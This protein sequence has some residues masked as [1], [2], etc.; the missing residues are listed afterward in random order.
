M[1]AWTRQFRAPKCH[2]ERIQYGDAA[3]QDIRV[4]GRRKP[5]VLVDCWDDV[6][7]SDYYDRS[8]KRSRRNRWRKV[9]D[10]GNGE[11][12]KC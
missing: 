10:M 3:E 11:G 7:R 6:T 9:A 8:W 2:N 1:A 5:R 12:G 4:R